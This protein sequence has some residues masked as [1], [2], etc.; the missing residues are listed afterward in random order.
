MH[1][2]VC[3][4]GLE[5]EVFAHTH[6]NT[7]IHTYIYACMCAQSGAEVE[8]SAHTY[9]NTY[10]HTYLH[11]CMHVCA[12]WVLKV[13]YSGLRDAYIKHHITWLKS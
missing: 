8:V 12:V 9:I 7:Y 4:L 6:I 1:A 2:C 3:S 13:K 10:I 11:I 5:V